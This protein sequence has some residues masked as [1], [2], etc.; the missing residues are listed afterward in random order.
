MA[1][2]G[3]EQRVPLNMVEMALLSVLNGNYTPEYFKELAQTEFV[4]ENRAKKMVGTLNSLVLRNP[5]LDDMKSQKEQTIAAFQ[6]KNDRPLLFTAMMSAAY[7]YAYDTVSVMGKYLH[8]QDQIT[9]DLL[10]KKMAEKYGSTRSVD[11]ARFAVLPMIVESGIIDRVGKGVFSIHKASH[12]SAFAET[13]YKKAFLC[14][15]PTLKFEDDTSTFP[16]FEFVEKE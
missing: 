9:T 10:I 4:G 8:V 1:K 6:R 16:F 3:I 11:M 7:P 15:N 13:L 2:L 14:N 12:F 5:L